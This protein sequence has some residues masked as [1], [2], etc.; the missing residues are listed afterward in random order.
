MRTGL[1]VIVLVVLLVYPVLADTEMLLVPATNINGVMTS[2]LS[3]G[4]LYMFSCSGTYSFGRDDPSVWADAEWC[5]TSGILAEYWPFPKDPYGTSDEVNDVLDLCVNDRAVA[6]LGTTN[7]LSWTPHTYSPTHEYRFFYA[8]TGDPVKL[9]IADSRPFTPLD[10]TDTNAG[11]LAVSI[12]PV[13]E[14][15]SIVAL[16]ALLTPLLAFRRR[17]A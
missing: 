7:G 16:G 1:L 14:P 11:H 12:T 6:W 10:E 2:A 9:H 3:A 8:G 4:Q 13:P 15:S 5:F 17:R